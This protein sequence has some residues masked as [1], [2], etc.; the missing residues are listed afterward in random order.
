MRLN[1]IKK[2]GFVSVFL[3]ALLSSNTYAVHCPGVQLVQPGS[4]LVIV[5]DPLNTANFISV[6]IKNGTTTEVGVALQDPFL[7]GLKVSQ[8]QIN[9]D[10]QKSLQVAALETLS[11][12]TTIEHLTYKVRVLGLGIAEISYLLP[13]TNNYLLRQ[14][15][16]TSNV[17]EC[18]VLSLPIPA[19]EAPTTTMKTLTST[20]YQGLF[21][22]APL[23]ALQSAYN[24]KL[25]E[26]ALLN[27]ELGS[28]RTALLNA[29]ESRQ[30]LLLRNN[31]LAQIF[32]DFSGKSAKIAVKSRERSTRTAIIKALKQARAAVRAL[33]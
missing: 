10:E 2:L 24:E 5:P 29:L 22:A 19:E 21:S 20:S 33:N 28:Y 23:A 3:S 27:D 4:A 8:L 6:A 32:S 12:G 25:I 13:G 1:S 7:G 17:D 26:L 16:L 11:D 30:K 14:V 31:S 9:A 15:D 18:S